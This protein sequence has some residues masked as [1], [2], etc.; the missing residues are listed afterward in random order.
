[1][2]RALDDRR[3]AQEKVGR[4]AVVDRDERRRLRAGSPRAPDPLGTVLAPDDDVLALGD[5]GGAQPAG[6]RAR[7]G[8]ASR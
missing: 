4:R 1:M 6:E 5:A 8:D 3:D 7:G 2:A